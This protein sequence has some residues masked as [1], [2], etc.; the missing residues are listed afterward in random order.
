MVFRKYNILIGYVFILWKL[1]TKYA[2]E[3]KRVDVVV[4]KEIMIEVNVYWITIQLECH[5]LNIY[6]S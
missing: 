4:S 6:H 5:N 3:L 1:I 2:N